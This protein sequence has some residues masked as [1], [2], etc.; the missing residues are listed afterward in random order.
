MSLYLLKRTAEVTDHDYTAAM[1]V[2]AH[3]EEAA[4][5]YALEFD[6]DVIWIEPASSSCEKLSEYGLEGVLMC[7]VRGITT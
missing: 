7:D 6:D 3:T 2:R 5:K 4:R 1:L